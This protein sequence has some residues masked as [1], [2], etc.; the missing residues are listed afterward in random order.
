MNEQTLERHHKVEPSHLRRDAYLYVRQ[1]T[2]RQVLENTES[3]KRQYE[4][5]ERALALGWSSEQVRVID[6][7]QGHSGATKAGRDG[8]QELVAE[9][10][11]GNAGLVMGLEVSRLARNSAD[12][13]RLLELCSFTNTLIL[14]QDGLYDPSTF[15]DRLLLGLKGT[16]SEAELHVLKSRLQQGILSK[17]RRGEL[18]MPLPAG[19]EYDELD[20]VVLSSDVQV[21]KALQRFFEVFERLGAAS[22]VVKEFRREGISMPHYSRIGPK[23]SRIIWGDLTHS[24]ALRILHNPRYAG[25]FVYGRVRAR[26]GPDGHTHYQKLPRDEWIALIPDSHEGYINWDQFESNRRRLTENANAYGQNNRRTPPREGPALLQGIVVCAVCGKRMSVRY[27]QRGKK[28]TPEYVCQRDK[29]EHGGTNNCQ[30]FPGADIDKAIAVMLVEMMNTSNIA[31]ALAVQKELQ[32]RVNETDNLR[33]QQVERQRY[34]ADLARR[35]YMRIDP[36]KRYVAEVL[37]AEWNKKLRLLEE[38]QTEYERARQRDRLLVDENAHEALTKLE[39]DFA[40]VWA[41]PSIPNRERKR[42]VRLLIEDVTLMRTEAVVAHIRFR[43]GTTR[44]LELPAALTAW[45]KYR[46]N[47]KV[48]RLIDRLLEQNTEAEIAAILN[49]R[50]YTSG[51]GNTFNRKRVGYIRHVYGFATRRKR[52]QAQGMVTRAE[53]CHLLRLSPSDIDLC[54]KNSWLTAYRYDSKRYLYQTLDQATTEDIKR[55]LSCAKSI[56]SDNTIEV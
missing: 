5:R 50:G 32:N 44:I 31:L 3:T 42:M 4:L 6:R 54:R 26:K 28:L 14:D 43:G 16:M 56:N 33:R 49:Q 20:R 45:Q 17:A 13:H 46:T 21:R 12:W 52:L 7:D 18:K 51:K 47:P 34:E 48:A 10:S 35:R 19:L 8:F 15:N 2:M 53:L 9:V 30:R 24:Q 40:E 23:S 29:I 55:K 25:A 38:A 1:S 22:A 41:S 36:D 39:R 11:L 37:E 27:H